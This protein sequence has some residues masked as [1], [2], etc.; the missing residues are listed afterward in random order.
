MIKP[1]VTALKLVERKLFLTILALLTAALLPTFRAAAPAFSFAT[2]ATFFGSSLAGV[3]FTTLTSGLA[4]TALLTWSTT[5]LLTS[6]SSRGALTLFL[7]VAFILLI[8]CHFL[9]LPD[10]SY[11]VSDE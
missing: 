2:F 9:S 7:V 3:L 1:I 8:V 11:V 4:L 10:C 5:L 6:C